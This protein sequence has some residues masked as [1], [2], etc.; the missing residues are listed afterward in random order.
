MNGF[1]GAIICFIE[2]ILYPVNM[3]NMSIG[4]TQASLRGKTVLH[5][6]WMKTARGLYVSSVSSLY[7]LR[8]HRAGQPGIMRWSLASAV[9]IIPPSP[10]SPPLK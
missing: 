4:A 2:A 10:P 8:L 9:C 7:H 1:C 6:I 3:L 5:R